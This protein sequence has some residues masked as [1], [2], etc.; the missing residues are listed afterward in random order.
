MQRALGELAV[1]AEGLGRTEEA[2][3]FRK[4]FAE[5]GAAQ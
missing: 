4:L 1:A 2:A 5:L 3:Q